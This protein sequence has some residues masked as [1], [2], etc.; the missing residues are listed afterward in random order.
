MSQI[1][2]RILTA[3]GD[4]VADAVVM[5]ADG[6]SHRDI[7]MLTDTAGRYRLDN[8]TAGDYTLLVNAEGYEPQRNQVT[9]GQSGVQALDIALG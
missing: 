6:P 9:V 3:S 7:A 2:G 5:I 4:P 1:S 8:L